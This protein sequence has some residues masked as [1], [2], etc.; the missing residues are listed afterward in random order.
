MSTHAAHLASLEA[1][2]DAATLD[3]QA[4]ADAILADA[5]D[6][7]ERSE[8]VSLGDYL[9]LVPGLAHRTVP[10]DA[11]I[12]AEIVAASESGTPVSSA[13]DELVARHPEFAP[14]IRDCAVLTGALCATHEIERLFSDTRALPCEFGPLLTSGAPRYVLLRVLGVGS[15]GSV[16]EAE[17]RV[18]SD[19]P[20]RALVALKVLTR[21]HNRFAD[22]HWQEAA[23]ANRVKHPNVVRALDRGTAPT[24]EQYAVFELVDGGD[25]ESLAQRQGPLHPD[26][27]ATLVA[28]TARGVHAS[29]QAGII[30][31]DL[32]PQ[33]VLLT[34]ENVPK[35][36][37]FGVARRHGDAGASSLPSGRIGGL[38][39]MAPEQYREPWEGATIASDVYALGGLLFWLL[40][41]ALPNGES[42]AEVER[43][44]AEGAAPA[45]REPLL[46]ERRVPRTLR[47]IILRAT[48]F[49]PAQ[50]HASAA[51]L[52]DEL[53]AFI[54]RR[55]VP[56]A[57]PSLIARATLWSRRHPTATVGL[58][59]LA[60]TLVGG[61]IVGLNAWRLSVERARQADAIAAASSLV[62][63]T[64]FKGDARFETESLMF[65]WAME[66]VGGAGLFPDFETWS[67]TAATER[68]N[69]VRGYI[70]DAAARGQDASIET[71]LWR[72]ALANLMLNSSEPQPEAAPLLAAAVAHLERTVGEDDELLL[73]ARA[74]Q[75]VAVV[76]SAFHQSERHGRASLGDMRELRE[77]ASQLESD[78]ER[79]RAARP[80]SPVF[81]LVLRAL[82]NLYRSALLAEPEA[83]SRI[84][85]ERDAYK[86]R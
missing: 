55:P 59:C 46:R 43:S 54:Q 30:H 1:L 72:I 5:A 41:G 60:L 81:L 31:A 38:G 80:G 26:D 21:A 22:I 23:K 40:T 29:H 48:A 83:R 86:Q 79:L 66:W 28:M 34:R 25:L 49:D 19:G 39:F 16:Y 78:L 20:A 50:R 68:M 9:A 14:Q 6:R 51:A 32:K 75:R 47:A 27:A 62:E 77:L 15:S 70:D 85:A 33:N 52:A 12:E 2:R 56:S 36:S 74:M 82:H 24:G 76:K 17:D 73:Q 63:Y 13:V 11:A 3:D 4:L 18:L 71:Q 69:V 57:H 8:P 61:A 64:K 84:V 7:R 42:R 37:D 45:W 67:T 44:L 35:V 53:D 65:L 10:L 58:G